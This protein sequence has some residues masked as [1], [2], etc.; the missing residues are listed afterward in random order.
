MK[1]V[2]FIQAVSYKET[3]CRLLTLATVFLLISADGH[4]QGN[5]LVTPK[6]LVF[7][8]SKR[9]EEI[10]LANVG[11]DSATYAISFIQI[12][13]KKDGSFEKITEPDSA[14]NF[15]D[16]YLRYFPRTVTLGP[17]EAQTVK[18]QLL[19][20]NELNPGEYRSHLYLR[21]VPNQK[22]LGEED[23]RNDTSIQVKL[24]PIFGISIPTIIRIGESNS[25]V[26]LTNLSFQNNDTVPT[27]K[28]QF[29]RSGNMSV[30]GDVSV[31]HV[32]PG[33]KIT[34]VGVVK[35]VAVYMPTAVRNF[36]LSLNKK[37]G[38]D[39]TSGKLQLVYSDQSLKTKLAETEFE[40]KKVNTFL[41]Q[42]K[43]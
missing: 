32:S 28:W 12:R 19:R 6:R 22:P 41:S 25:K 13:M 38:V 7:D 21:A 27:L 9:S 18:V 17:N 23:K 5:L 35:G 30:Y 34:P 1:K 36:Q 43:K 33:G 20:T 37:A 10:N 39:F 29:N 2:F 3:F 8:G 4:A 26:S 11:S 42:V 14:Q 40:L 24:V 15:A 31:N 16:K